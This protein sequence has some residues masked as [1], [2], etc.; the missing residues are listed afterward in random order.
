MAVAT[1]GI[2]VKKEKNKPSEAILEFYGLERGHWG[3]CVKFTFGDF[4]ELYPWT[5]LVFVLNC[6]LCWTAWNRR[7]LGVSKHLPFKMPLCDWGSWWASG[8]WQ[9]L[10][11]LCEWIQSGCF[12]V[13]QPPKEL[14]WRYSCFMG[15]T[16]FGKWREIEEAWKVWFTGCLTIQYKGRVGVGWSGNQGTGD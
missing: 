15:V 2:I 8:N 14:Q 1:V 4:S 13:N 5:K 12:G 9:P 7:F 16:G 6:L 10:A 11:Y 3:A